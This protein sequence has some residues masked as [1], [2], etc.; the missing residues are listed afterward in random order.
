MKRSL[1]IQIDVKSGVPASHQ[2]VNRLRTYLVEGELV[3]GDVLPSIRRL[4]IELGIH[5]NTVAQAYRQLAEERWID[6]HQGRRVIVVDRKPDPLQSE[7]DAPDFRQ[8]LR[9]L[10]AQLRAQGVPPSSLSEELR[11]LA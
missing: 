10:V 1:Q 6:L 11:I 2:I 8:N 9:D 4:A 5:F 3:P 7:R